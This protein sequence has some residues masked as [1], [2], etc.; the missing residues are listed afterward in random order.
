MILLTE[1][2]FLTDLDHNLTFFRK[3]LLKKVGDRLNQGK[4]KCQNGNGTLWRQIGDS[5]LILYLPQ[6]SRDII[7]GKVNAGCLQLF[8]IQGFEL[9]FRHRHCHSR[10]TDSQQARQSSA[11]HTYF[12]E[13]LLTFLELGESLDCTRVR[14]YFERN[15][16]D[17]LL[18]DDDSAATDYFTDFK[19][20]LKNLNWIGGR[21][22]R[23]EDRCDDTLL[24][25][26]EYGDLLLSD[27]RFLILEFEC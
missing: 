14:L 19:V 12:R 1:G 11:T 16:D 18:G 10:Y 2:K 17:C 4:N 27:E 15:E 5:Y 26:L 8:I 22:V 3:L 25:K 6:H 21:M 9:L 13:L 23:N 24:E 7:Y 20:I